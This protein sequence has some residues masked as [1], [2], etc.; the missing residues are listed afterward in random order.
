MTHSRGRIVL[1][2]GM[3]RSGTSMLARLL[4]ASGLPLGATLLKHRSRD[5]A[6]GYW[7]QAEIV[8]IHEAMLDG[9][10][11]TWHGPNGLRPLPDGWLLRHET[12]AAKR[13]LAAIV[14]REMTQAG[15][16]WGFKDPR[17]LRFLPLWREI[18]DEMA[19][20]PVF[21]MAARAPG[22]VTASLMGRNRLPRDIAEALWAGNTLTLLGAVG[23]DLAAVVDYDAWFTKPAAIAAH[24]RA[25]I[26]LPTSSAAETVSPVA[27]LIEPRLR[28]H[29][30]AAGT[31]T[32]FDAL[33][34]A[35]VSETP[36][37]PSAGVLAAAVTQA[38]ATFNSLPLHQKLAFKS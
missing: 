4:A 13:Q 16:L 1:I 31:S 26:G 3:H 12:R 29:R 11:R 28:H 32:A 10:D 14:D 15:G 35:L 33:H 9:F 20:E 5:N 38:A 2:L 37:A 18:I 24:L 27:T 22:A 7:E 8:P 19:L 23:S 17:T 25:V 6:H 36:R 21:I 34:A 30:N